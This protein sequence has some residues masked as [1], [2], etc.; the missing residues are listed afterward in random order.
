MS[1]QR[2]SVESVVVLVTPHEMG[3]KPQSLYTRES[4]DWATP[5]TQRIAEYTYRL[6]I[7]MTRLIP[8]HLD[9]PRD[10]LLVVSMPSA[11]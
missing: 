2:L 9:A 3:N 10:L 11:V 4:M 8:M 7:W 5:V 6:I 1:R